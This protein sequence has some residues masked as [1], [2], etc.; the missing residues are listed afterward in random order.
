MVQLR[1]LFNLCPNIKYLSINLSDSYEHG[2]LGF[3]ISKMK[4]NNSHLFFLY[5]NYFYADIQ[6][7]EKIR[8]MINQENLLENYFLDLF[9]GNMSLWC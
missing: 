3:L 6:L 1:F 4:K 9:K 2:I 5:L 7:L 8:S